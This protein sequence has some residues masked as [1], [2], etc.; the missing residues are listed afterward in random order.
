M[1]SFFIKYVHSVLVT[2]ICRPLP[3]LNIKQRSFPELDICF[4]GRDVFGMFWYQEY[5]L[6][7]ITGETP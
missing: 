7:E 1:S 2:N 6:S 5:D 4:Q 3:T